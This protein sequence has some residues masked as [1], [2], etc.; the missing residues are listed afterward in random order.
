MCTGK[1][2]GVKEVK[3]GHK[4]TPRQ[5]SQYSDQATNR[6]ILIKFKAGREFFRKGKNFHNET[7]R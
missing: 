6:K 5:L 1:L 7:P 4:E 2:L 3:N